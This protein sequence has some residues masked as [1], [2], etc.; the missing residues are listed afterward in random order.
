MLL[1]RSPRRTLIRAG[2]LAIVLLVA[3]RVVLT[4]LR[5]HGPSMLP[6]YHEG[7]LLLVNRL[8]YRLGDPTRGDI[9]AIRL[10]GGR[11]ALVKRIIGLPGERVRIAAGTVLIDGEPL[12]E[13]Y[14]RHRLPWDVAEAALGRNEY[15]VIG[16]N[17]GMPPGEHDFG[18]T[19][20]ARLLGRLVN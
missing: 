4:P 8:A 20:R 13:P 9:V 2:L 11:A 19:I 3:S 6:T 14:V 7:Q 16:D 18:R 12:T 15:F 5:A 17:R 1:G 10:A